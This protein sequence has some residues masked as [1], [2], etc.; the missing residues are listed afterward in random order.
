MTPEKKFAHAPLD[1]LHPAREQVPVTAVSP[2][3][4][5]LLAYISASDPSTFSSFLDK[6]VIDSLAG[7]RSQVASFL[8]ASLL[9]LKPVFPIFAPEVAAVSFSLPA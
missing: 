7:D 2:S 5:S 8:L 1:I 6:V 3:P 9:S 4:C